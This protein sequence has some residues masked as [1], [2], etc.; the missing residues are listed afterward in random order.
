VASGREILEAL[1][2]RLD[3]LRRDAEAL[4]AQFRRTSDALAAARRAQLAAFAGL[5]RMR[6]EDIASGEL[7]Q[8]F[9]D[10]DRQVAEVLQVRKAAERSLA[11]KLA[12]AER[13]L[14]T[15]E[16]ERARQQSAVAE[17]ARAADD[18]ALQAKA[19]LD[20][21]EEYGSKLAAAREAHAIAEHA[22]TKAAAA[23]G[24]RLV[25]TKP[26]DAD[27]VFGYLWQKG[28]GTPAYRS[29][30]LTRM[31][32][33]AVARASGY[34]L[35]RRNYWLLHETPRRLAEHARRMRLK[36]NESLSAAR[37]LESEA[38]N[39]ADLP[40]KQ[41]TLAQA[42]ERLAEIDR[43]IEECE[44]AVDSAVESRGL[45]AAGEDEHSK[46]C[47]RL[48]VEALERADMHEL[49]K[50]A[51]RT[52]TEDDDRLLE[53][54]ERLEQERSSLQD[55]LIRLRRLHQ[56]HRERTLGLEEVRHRFKRS[57]FDDVHSEFAN[58]PLIET[59]LDQFVAGSMDS[60]ELWEGIG[61]QHRGTPQPVAE[62]GTDTLA[63][64][65]AR[66]RHE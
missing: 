42:K 3:T 24:D 12:T 27:P 52:T 14:A 61:R 56:T 26:Y 16:A 15:A 10:T 63:D 11:A 37:S 9:D 28:Y 6:L 45:F 59:L 54:L 50:K 66:N 33:G 17:A 39:A 53:E 4:D 21:N 58:G 49:R 55:E 25:K 31:L 19:R 60:D 62:F 30:S 23:E 20:A 1:D 7:L 44:A 5:A 35:L 57:R 36:A 38:A 8:R 64:A 51:V 32:D 22:E 29:S 13:A 34:E 47:T 40:S 43:A 2:R 46:R 18:A 65:T 48:L 41:R